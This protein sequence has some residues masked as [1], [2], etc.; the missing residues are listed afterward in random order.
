MRIRL[1]T[2]PTMPAALARIRA[3]LGPDAVILSSRRLPEGVEVTA[4]R[5]E[6]DP[7]TR[8]PPAPCPLA[9]HGTPPALAAKLRAGPL[10]FALSV[11]LRFQPIDTTALARGLVFVGPPGAGKTLTLARLATRLVLAGARPRIVTA[12]DRRAGA[13]E[14]LA[15]Y[16]ELL[17]L[18]LAR[19]SDGVPEGPGPLLIDS[20]G[21]DPFTPA[22]QDE[23]AALAGCNG[24]IPVL[25]L[26]AGLDAGEAAD[27]AEGFA[28]AGAARLAVTRL[29]VARRLGGVLAA[30]ERLPLAEA[31]IGPTAPSGLVPMT[32][33]I[34]AARL[35]DPPMRMAG[36]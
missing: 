2:A 30:A 1:F 6:P 3:E 15:A 8:R 5:D 4:A 14:Q 19:L 25:V 11:A 13:Y 21:L 29:D 17:D 35:R 24:A 12:D 10:P 33:D 34:L 27:L 7:A 9:A 22:D 36:R 18:P 23:L 20:P 28:A 32:P 26:P 31:G 16:T